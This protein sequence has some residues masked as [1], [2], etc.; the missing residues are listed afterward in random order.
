M[1]ISKCLQAAPQIIS[2][3]AELWQAVHH[4][5]A[6]DG[7]AKLGAGVRPDIVM[8]PT[9]AALLAEHVAAYSRQQNVPNAA[10]AGLASIQQPGVEIP[11][12]VTNSVIG[13][14]QQGAAPVLGDTLGATGPEEAPHRADELT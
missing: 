13:A 7:F 12:E 1:K 4:A 8:G 5:G 6:A 11:P 14:A 10:A 3:D 9:G 2:D